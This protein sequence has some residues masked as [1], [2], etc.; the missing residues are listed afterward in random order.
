MARMISRQDAAELLDCNIQTVTNWVERGLLKGHIIGRALMVDRDSIE[1][2]FD[3]LKVLAAMAQQI[4]DIKSEY[5]TVIKNLKEVLDEAKGISITPARARDAFKAN[6]L[7]LIGL[8]K[9]YLKSREGELFSALIRGEKLDDVGQRFGLTKE[10]I[11]QIAI[12]TADKLSN[13]KELKE[14]QEQNNVLKAENEQLRQL[15]SERDVQLNEF[16]MVNKLAFTLFEKR[17]EDFNL[18]TRTLNGLH[19]K[20]CKIIAD[21]VKFDRADLMSARNFGQKCFS[22]VDE[23][24]S[25]LG[26]HWGMDIDLMTKEELKKWT[27]S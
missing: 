13:I 22:E 20:N 15:L 6:Q 16:E 17:L 19:I 11:V 1:Q 12:K 8:C 3:D 2:Y 24:V 21:L 26:L 25:S 9:D 23:L 18:S 14:I 5:Q 27:K 4:S 10:R 7:T